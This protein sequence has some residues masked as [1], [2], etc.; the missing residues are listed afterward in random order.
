[1][2]LA[3]ECKEVALRKA[4]RR[5]RKN[6]E[7]KELEAIAR[8]READ[9]AEA[10]RQAAEARLQAEQREQQQKES[11]DKGL[12]EEAAPAGGAF[13]Q[14][15]PEPAEPNNL[16]GSDFPPVAERQDSVSPF[17]DIMPDLN[18]DLADLGG[19]GDDQQ[20]QQ[21]FDNGFGFDDDLGGDMQ[22]PGGGGE[23]DEQQ[24]VDHLEDLE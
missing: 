20:Y 13:E 4:R 24:S 6:K 21:A 16:G 3:L 15:D 22:D 8:Q 2:K 14:E 7:I 10:L 5:I 19:G 9:E 23:L 12:A 11:L 17:D 18:D 1:M